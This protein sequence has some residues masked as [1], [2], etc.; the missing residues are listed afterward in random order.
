VVGETA[1]IVVDVSILQSVSLVGS[2]KTSG[3]RHPKIRE[4]LMIGAGAKIHGTIE[5]GR[6]AKIGAGSDVLHPVPPHTT[7]AVV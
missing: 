1:V 2:G 7:A 5:E 4:G 6:A 3:D